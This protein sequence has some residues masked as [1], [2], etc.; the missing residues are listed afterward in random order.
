MSCTDHGFKGNDAWYHRT[1][2][3]KL[4]HR[5]VWCNANGRDIAAL[6]PKEV[7]RHTCDNTRCVNPAHLV[8]GTQADNV[9]DMMHRG[10]H[11]ALTNEK[12]GSTVYPDAMCK[13]IYTEYHT[14]RIGVRPLA[15]KYGLSKSH[16]HNIVTGANRSG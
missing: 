10:R 9:A 11:V 3:G 12:H 1:S 6:S 14:T 7:V 8:I 5:V 15:R 2:K 16:V 13:A 4:L